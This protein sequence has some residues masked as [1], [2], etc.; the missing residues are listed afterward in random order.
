MK[1]FLLSA[2]VILVFT[3]VLPAQSVNQE[4]VVQYKVTYWTTDDGLPGNSCVKIFQDIDGFLWMGSFD[5]LVRFDGTR[6]ITYNK[7]NLL[8]SNFALAMT[9]DKQG[10]L[11]VGTDHGLSQYYKGKI[12]DLADEDH[13]FFVES[14]LMDE[15][16]HKVWIGT[17]NAGFF[18]YD[19]STRKYNKIEGPKDDDI[20]NDIIKDPDGSLWVAG[21]KN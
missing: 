6:F 4:S 8:S 17:R 18:S 1:V 10:N 21:E 2:G 15:E 16:Q 3:Q 12:V 5:G 9:G 14:V 19:I 7:A 11:W 20:I 13:N